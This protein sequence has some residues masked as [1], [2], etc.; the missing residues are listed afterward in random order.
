MIYSA[1]RI[2]FLVWDAFD[3]NVFLIPILVPTQLQI[4]LI[5]SQVDPA[6]VTLLSLCE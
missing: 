6:T 2:G 4:G 1:L 5:P 3:G